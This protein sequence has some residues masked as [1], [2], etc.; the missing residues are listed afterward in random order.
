MALKKRPV[1]QSRS[2]AVDSYAEIIA[3]PNAGHELEHLIDV[4]KTL[5]NVEA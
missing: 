4:I 1:Q 5:S 3:S 2:A